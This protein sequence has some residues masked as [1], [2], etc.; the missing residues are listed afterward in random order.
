[1]SSKDPTPGLLSATFPVDGI[2]CAG[3]VSRVEKALLALAGVEEVGVNLATG[4][5]VV[6]FLPE[7]V[8]TQEMVEAVEGVGYKIPIGITEVGVQGM[9]CAACVSRV[10]KVLAGAPGVLGAEVSLATEAAQLRFVPGMMGLE[11][12]KEIVDASGY[13]LREDD[14]EGFEEA[15]KKREEE[16]EG[17]YRDLLRRFWVGAALG[18]PVAIIGHAHLLP[19]LRN[20]S[21]ENLRMLWMVSGV[22]TLPIMGYVGRRF[23][24]GAWSAFRHRDATMDTLVAL[25]TGS[26][27][28]YSTVAVL[29]PGLFPEGT[30]HPFYE[31]TAVV[32]TL[33]ML[34]QALE[35]RAKGR[36]SQALRRLMDLRPRLARVIRGGEEVGIPAQEVQ[37]GDLL[38]VRPGEKIPVDGDVT[39]G[40]SAVDE[41]MVTGESLP[42]EK[43]LGDAVVAGTINASG[44]FRFRAG[45]VGKDTL[46]AHIVDMVRSAQGSKPSIQRV[47]DVVASYFVPTVMI[48]ATLTF[49]FWYTFGP[50]PRLSFAAVVAVAVLVIAC[51]CALGLATPISIMVSVGKAAQ[52]G[53]LVR[54][55]D[56]LQGARQVDTILLDKTGTLTKGEPAL[57]AIYPAAGVSEEDFLTLMAGVEEGSEHP[58]AHAVVA[59]ARERGLSWTAPQTF[60]AVTGRGVRASLDGEELLAGSPT[61]LEG[62]GVTSTEF[63]EAVEAVTREGRTPVALARGGSYLGTLGISDP[64]KEDSA[65]VVAELQRQGLQVLMLT[66][67]HEAAAA[68]IGEEVGVDGVRAQLLPQEK[69]E[70]VR[71]LQAKGHRV[72][73]VGDGIND[74]PALAQADVGIALGGGTDVAM[75]TGDMVLMGSSLTGVVHA[76]ELSRATFRNIRQNLFGA[77]FYNVLGIPIAAGLLYPF[78]GLLLSP[79][80]AG[81]AMAFSSVTVVTNANRLRFFEPTFRPGRVSMGAK[82]GSVPPADGEA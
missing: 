42:V 20:L 67:D 38:V 28:I 71:E 30:A 15:L 49:A 16:R 33:V 26:A 17:E 54:N 74:A 78:F 65:A 53:I 60:E 40:Q 41:S 62:E 9:H 51:P 46:L 64:V 6:S 80:I 4:E 18:L 50:E 31:A 1:M 76:L 21:H 66:G 44:T 7:L 61:F 23:F 45:R 73:M 39:Q 29:F 63:S 36:T 55:G 48:I 37:V 2:H 43:G 59:G 5:A 10:E 19:G 3:C 72:A 77:F 47:V 12:L 22:L 68:A 8:S 25:G 14:G 56:A 35:A 69:A 13:T 79:V 27:W 34:G 57:T 81:S 58:L 75:E 24:T 52:A 32:I 70:A 11:R 82:T